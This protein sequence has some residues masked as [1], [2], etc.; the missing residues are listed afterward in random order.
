MNA[1]GI[2]KG[3]ILCIAAGCIS[4]QSSHAQEENPAEPVREVVVE[5]VPA[6]RVRFE[7]APMVRLAPAR[8]VIQDGK[9]RNEAALES[10]YKHMS[11]LVK[12]ELGILFRV[13]ELSDEEKQLMRE[14]TAAKI[15]ETHDILIPLND[16][17]EFQV[18]EN[19]V[20]N[21]DDGNSLNA[22]PFT[23]ASSLV[24]SVAKKVL[25]AEKVKQYQDEIAAQ[26]K[27]Q[28]EAVVA[29][30]VVHLDSK[31]FL[32]DEQFEKITEKLVSRWLKATDVNPEAYLMDSQYLPNVPINLIEPELDERQ[33]E[34]W[35][36]IH[37]VNFPLQVSLEQELVGDWDE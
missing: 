8:V 23:R 26:Q 1:I 7:V 29:V 6:E 13:C 20:A 18:S 15:P 10:L 24:V 37:R 2:C 25:P 16:D 35:R 36:T 17:G 4:A 30:I 5:E 12:R 9:Q 32:T 3:V 11:Y 33:V 31:L 22:N 19:I 28:R 21:C 34:I 27:K 14:Q